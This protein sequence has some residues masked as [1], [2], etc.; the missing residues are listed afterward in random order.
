MSG[1]IAGTSSLSL[2]LVATI[3]VIS[4]IVGAIDLVRQPGWAWKRAEES[5]AAWLVLVAL[6]P[7]VGLGMYLHSARPKVASIAA[8]GRAASLPFEHFGNDVGTQRDTTWPIGAVAPPQRFVKVGATVAT[9]SEI[10]LVEAAEDGHGATWAG[11]EFFGG[12]GTTVRSAMAQVGVTRAYRPKQ[13][14]SLPVPSPTE[15]APSGAAVPAGWK[16]DP[17]G[18][19]QFRYWGGN[20]WTENVA[21]NGEQ[22][23]DVATS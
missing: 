14:T 5:K 21:D 7:L 13:R 18:R 10:R 1:Q 3:V 15:G 12:G 2:E 8:A 20:R 16:A 9:D 11:N 17:T 19:H 22:S 4:M 23:T 6:V